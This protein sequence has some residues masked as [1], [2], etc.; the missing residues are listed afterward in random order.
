MPTV[1]N[2]ITEKC[3]LCKDK[4]IE[5]PAVYDA[6]IPGIGS[7][8]FVCEECFKRYRCQLGLGKGQKLK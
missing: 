7:W 2:I 5:R 6:R 4:L 8:A 3:D 1:E